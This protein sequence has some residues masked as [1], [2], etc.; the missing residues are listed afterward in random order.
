MVFC[1]LDQQGPVQAYTN[2]HGLLRNPIQKDDV[3]F[4]LKSIDIPSNRRHCLDRSLDDQL[5]SEQMITIPFWARFR[6]QDG[7]T[8]WFE[9]GVKEDATFHRLGVVIG[10]GV[11]DDNFWLVA[12]NLDAQGILGMPGG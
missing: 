9:T 5:P 8:A 3:F 10:H 12:R 4:W 1:V 2:Q 11:R 7:D 6:M